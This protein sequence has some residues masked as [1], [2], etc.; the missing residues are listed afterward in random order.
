MAKKQQSWGWVIG[1]VAVVVVLLAVKMYSGTLS[2]VSSDDDQA[3]SGDKTG[4]EPFLATLMPEDWK[5]YANA[6]K[7]IQSLLANQEITFYVVEDP[8]DTNL[9]Y[10][11]AYAYNND[12]KNET[13]SIYKYTKSTYE[14]ERIWRQTYAS[15]DVAW[16]GNTYSLP[17]WRLVGYDNGKLIVLV[18][19][20]DNSPGICAQPF[21]VGI[22]NENVARLF[23]LD[24]ANPSAGLA[25]Y[26]PNEELVGQAT[27][28]Q[29][30]CLDVM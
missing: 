7:D 23:T 27:A 18:E 2:R 13:L 21:L 6:K 5:Y 24:L 22:D 29:N 19:D 25:P 30:E 17:V 14:Y 9:A 16:M 12:L 15:G 26:T 1:I 28:K 4:V 3:Y 20:S 8:Q 11:A 10:F